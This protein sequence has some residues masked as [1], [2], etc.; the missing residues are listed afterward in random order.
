M[1]YKFTFQN[2]IKLNKVYHFHYKFFSWTI[3]G[4][5]EIH[6]GTI[7]YFHG[8]FLGKGWKTSV[9]TTLGRGG[10][11]LNAIAIGKA[12]GLRQIHVW[13]DVNGVMTCDPNGF[14]GLAVDH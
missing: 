6:V 8:K 7:N 11:D 4:V 2:R 13:K 3:Q 10:R 9:V 5:G 12:L 14:G 1:L